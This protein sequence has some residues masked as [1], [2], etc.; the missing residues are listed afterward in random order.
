MSEIKEIV[1]QYNTV[2]RPLSLLL[3]WG[4]TTLTPY[5]DGDI[6][7]KI[8]FETLKKIKNDYNYMRQLAEE[9]KDKVTDKDFNGLMEAIK[10]FIVINH[11]LK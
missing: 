7:L 9:N 6:P 11:L 1:E 8:Y 10:Y 5:L 4:E 3:A 2:I